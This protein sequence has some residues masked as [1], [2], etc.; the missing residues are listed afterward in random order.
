MTKEQFINHWKH[1][2]FGMVGDAL[3]TRR[4]GTETGMALD[5]AFRKIEAH[6]ARMFEQLCPTAQPAVN[7]KPA[8]P[9]QPVR[10]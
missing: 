4:N 2:F 5:L 6:L 10:K 9:A 7:G 3:A 1:E 8:A